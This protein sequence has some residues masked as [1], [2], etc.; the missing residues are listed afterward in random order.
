MI[1][2]ERFICQFFLLFII[3][4]QNKKKNL[5]QIFVSAQMACGFFIFWCQNNFLFFLAKFCF[6]FYINGLDIFFHTWPVNFLNFMVS[7]IPN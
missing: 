3:S 1:P 4:I 6:V 2:C 7:N 5:E